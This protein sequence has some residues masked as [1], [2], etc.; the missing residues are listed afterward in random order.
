M[1]KNFWIIDMVLMFNIWIPLILSFIS[2][3]S[4][5]CYSFCC[6]FMRKKYSWLFTVSR[7]SFITTSIILILNLYITV[8]IGF[9]G[10]GPAN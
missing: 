7:I 2:I 5:S 1:S 6:G 8:I 3:I 9:I 10:I 4:I